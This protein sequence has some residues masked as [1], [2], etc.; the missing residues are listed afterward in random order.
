MSAERKK[1]QSEDRKH[2]EAE[3]L[4]DWIH[5]DECCHLETGR[6]GRM[7]RAF[8]GRRREIQGILSEEH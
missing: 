4:H 1:E 5:L 6:G 7:Q 3:H 2:K 8:G